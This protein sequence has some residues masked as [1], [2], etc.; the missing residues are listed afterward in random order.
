MRL[1]F[2]SDICASVA[3]KKAAL[4]DAAWEFR[5]F[6]AIR[7]FGD[8]DFKHFADTVLRIQAWRGR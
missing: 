2:V 8:Q 3:N 7:R 4:V 1:F 6:P 5:T